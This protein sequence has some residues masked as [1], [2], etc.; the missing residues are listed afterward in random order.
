MFS[1]KADHAMNGDLGHSYED[2][3]DDFFEPQAME[4]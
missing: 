4:S 3:D 2:M 1:Q